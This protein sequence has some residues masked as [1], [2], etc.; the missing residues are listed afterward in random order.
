MSF[1]NNQLYI[2]DSNID[3]TLEFL[4]NIHF[5]LI[6]ALHTNKQGQCITETGFIQ[7]V[8]SLGDLLIFIDE[9][10]ELKNKM[11]LIELIDVHFV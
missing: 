3:K 5:T 11:R 2:S 7:F 6:E 9:V 8:D 4:L 10:F 1:T